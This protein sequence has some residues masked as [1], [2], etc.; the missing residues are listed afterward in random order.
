LAIP[1]LANKSLASITGGDSS[2]RLFEEQYEVEP[3]ARYM[4][5][6]ATLP[7]GMILLTGG[8]PM[9]DMARNFQRVPASA[10]VQIYDPSYDVYYSAAAMSTPRAR[11]ASVALRDGRIAVLGGFNLFPLNSVE[12]Y[13]PYLDTWSHGGEL[14]HPTFDHAV[15]LSGSTV[16]LSGGH[17]GASAIAFE[18]STHHQTFNP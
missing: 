3:T 9:S 8:Y 12:I 2:F 15:A 13:D 4:N 11:H 7:N 14:P 6:A 10:N 1:L 18:I 16:I 17:S 5:S